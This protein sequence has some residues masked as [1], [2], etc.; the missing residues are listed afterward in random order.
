MGGA[1]I[2]AAGVGDISTSAAALA[3]ENSGDKP[4]ND[5]IGKYRK[6]KGLTLNKQ[7]YV[8]LLNTK[9][10]W[11]LVSTHKLHPYTGMAVDVKAGQTI[12][13]IQTEGPQIMDCNFM[14]ADTQDATGEIFDYGI[15]A[16]F[17]GMIL[18]RFGRLWS[19][20]PYFR[21]IATY[22][23]D[24][25]DPSTVPDGHWPV[26]IG[27]HCN[28][29]VIEAS[30]GI[31]NHH[32]CHT[33]FV[34]AARSRG[35]D[36][37]VARLPNVNLF[38]PMTVKVVE[39]KGGYMAP[40]WYGSPSYAKKGEYAEFYAEIDLLCLPVHCP[41]GDQSTGPD[42]AIDRTNTIEIWETGTR[43]QPSPEWHDWR[44]D[45]DAELKRPP[46]ERSKTF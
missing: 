46:N 23:D 18:G 45:F 7:W 12:R 2:V 11:K 39:Q 1:G 10:N 8:D 19:N 41:Y 24:N 43:P 16:A 13:L 14:A 32:S 22:I 34:E 20:N 26:W 37:S 29:E 27:P 36:E 3:D 42:E 33:N 35:M 30:I 4:V 5:P 40:T 6:A 21:P 17:E 25:I 28:S 31:K 38:Q 9:P 15:T 44:V